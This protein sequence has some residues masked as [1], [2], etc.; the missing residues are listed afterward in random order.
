MIDVSDGIATDARH[1]AERSDVRVEIELDRLPLAPGVTDPATAATAG[2]DY[3]LLF[4]APPGVEVPGDVT[5]IGQVSEG[6]GL[7][8]T[9]SG[10]PVELSGFEH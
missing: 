9:R 5:W 3:E 8:L 6:E 7:T 1:I 4:T 10:E 2:E